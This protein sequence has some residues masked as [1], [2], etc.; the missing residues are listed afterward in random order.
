MVFE[1][2]INLVASVVYLKFSHNAFQQMDI[3]IYMLPT[4]AHTH[5]D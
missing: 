2:A 3:L 5:T 4:G 1:W